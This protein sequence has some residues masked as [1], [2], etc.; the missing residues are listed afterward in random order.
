MLI[1]T[2]TDPSQPPTSTFSYKAGQLTGAV[3]GSLS[4]LLWMATLWDPASPFLFSP[5]SFIVVLGM[6]LIAILV[7][8][9]SIKGNSTM[10]LVLFFVAFL[11]IGLY[12]IGV[13]HWIRWV[14][15]TNLG[16]LLAGLLLRAHSSGPDSGPTQS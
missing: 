15:L 11:P 5:A 2:M 16:Y 6:I 10:L 3:A 9:A 13:P 4:C 1:K 8:I 14:G 12:V 7:V